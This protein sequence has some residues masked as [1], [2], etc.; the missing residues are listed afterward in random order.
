MKSFM[1]SKTRYILPMLK[2][3]WFGML[4][5]EKNVSG[6]EKNVRQSQVEVYR[7]SHPAECNSRNVDA[8]PKP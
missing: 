4:V 2:N 1:I 8:S 6:T 3:T 5:S 7:V